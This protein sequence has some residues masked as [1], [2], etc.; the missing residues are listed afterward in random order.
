LIRYLSDKTSLQKD[1]SNRT[2]FMLLPGA[3]HP[4]EGFIEHGFVQAVR[5]RDLPLDLL[6]VELPFN[7]IADTSA[8]NALHED[9]IQ[10]AKKAG[11]ANIWI[12]GISIGG[13]MAIAY[14]NAYPGQLSG[15]CL[16]APYPGNR[17]TTNEIAVAGGL[18]QWVPEGVA[19]D[20]TERHTW[21]WL[22]HHNA[23]K[24]KVYLGYG[25][26]DRFAEGH[27]MMAA[28]LPE[29]RVDKVAGDHTWPVWQQLW[30]RFLDK[31][32]GLIQT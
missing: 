18:R 7:H 27:A 22:K 14:E 28:V 6:M 16:L 10:P 24:P 1:V 13:Y 17:M 25:I 29:H 19:E 26:G 15:I 8:I 32:F 12:A 2:L 30:Q 31:E 4:P 11:Y 3:N 21:L 20:D 9:I 5:E 23:A